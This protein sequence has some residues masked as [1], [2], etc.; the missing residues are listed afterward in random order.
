MAEE[1]SQERTEEATP[2]RKQDAKEKGQAAR[3]KELNTSIVM[4][5]GSAG[6][7]M[8]GQSLCKQLL[9]MGRE[10]LYFEHKFIFD[11]HYIFNLSIDLLGKVIFALAPLLAVLLIASLLGP[12]MLAGWAINLKSIQPKFERINPL[13]GLKR[14]F[15]L[16]GLVELLKALLKFIMIA[17]VGG[18]IIWSQM[19]KL[20]SLGYTNDMQTVTNGVS[21]MAWLF[22]AV[23]T[24]LLVVAAVD[25]P[26]QVWEHLKQLRMTKQE[27]R[28]EHKEMEGKPEVKGQIRRAQQEMANQRMVTEVPKA[29]VIITNPTHYAVALKYDE[30]S[31]GAPRVIA[32]GRDY[33][34]LQI[35]TIASQNRVAI[36]EAP[37]LARALY[38]TTKVGEEI[39]HGL[40]VAVAQVLAY[41]YQL[42]KPRQPGEPRRK[43]PKLTIPDDMQY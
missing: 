20:M 9:A 30:G 22:L 39:P 27:I 14:I 41:V 12:V 16:R 1:S 33:L 5:A 36:V 26:Y 24:T 6:L 2:K 7:L 23:S 8:Y 17:C 10:A 34:A 29:D 21:L 43:L 4:L 42:K 37:P 18:T 15:A 13:K 40:Y 3:S 31:G 38:H 32:S 35:R 25:V 28:D 11:D 19:P